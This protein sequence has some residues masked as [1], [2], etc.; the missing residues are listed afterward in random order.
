MYTQT[1]E[2]AVQTDAVIG[3]RGYLH[4][5]ASGKAI[6]AALPDERVKEILDEHGMPASTEHT[7]I[8][9]DTLFTELEEILDTGVAFN[10][11]ESTMG[12]HAV[13]TAICDADGRPVGALSISGPAHR[14]K[15]K[16]FRQELPNLV[17]ASANELELKLEFQ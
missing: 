17:L 5:S 14:L 13:A 9:V 7:T 4:S 3:K 8:D 11:E 15:G 12:L 2:N 10:E 1:G 16:P 6:L